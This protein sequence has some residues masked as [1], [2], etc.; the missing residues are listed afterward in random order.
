MLYTVTLDVEKIDYY[1]SKTSTRYIDRHRVSTRYRK[2]YRQTKQDIR[3]NSNRYPLPILTCLS[4]QSIDFI[5]GHFTFAIVRNM[6]LQYIKVLTDRPY[7]L[8][9]FLS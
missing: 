4:N 1:W 6:G 9:Q 3:N 2:I 7:E 5:S 8:Y